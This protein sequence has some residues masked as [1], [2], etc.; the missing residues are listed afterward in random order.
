[1]NSMPGMAMAPQD[2]AVDPVCGMSVSP[3]DQLSY[4]FGG[5]KYSFCSDE[6]M[7]KF[8][9]NPGKYITPSQQ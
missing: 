2:K 4:S 5:K 1:M 8:K 3:S 7:E 9:G 6:D